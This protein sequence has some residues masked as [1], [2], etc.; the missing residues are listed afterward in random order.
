ML[1]QTTTENRVIRNIPQTTIQ[2]PRPL[3]AFSSFP[4]HIWNELSK[5]NDKNQDIHIF[6][7]SHPLLGQTLLKPVSLY[8]LL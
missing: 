4:L 8:S 7:S 1:A 3:N 2:L 5:N 6:I